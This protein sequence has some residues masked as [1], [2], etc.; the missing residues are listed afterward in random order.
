MV[1]FSEIKKAMKGA[2]SLGELRRTIQDTYFKPKE[3]VSQA[4]TPVAKK[5]KKAV[6]KNAG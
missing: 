3:E 6:K 5:P 2:S 1:G 4:S